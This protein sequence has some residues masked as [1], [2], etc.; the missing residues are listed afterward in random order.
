MIGCYRC[1]VNLLLQ[2]RKRRFYK[3]E[4]QNKMYKFAHWHIKEKGKRGSYA[5]KHTQ[6][7]IY[8]FIFVIM[9]HDRAHIILFLIKLYRNKTCVQ[10]FYKEIRYRC[11]RD[12]RVFIQRCITFCCLLF[13]LFF[14]FPLISC[15]LHLT[16]KKSYKN[17]RKK[18]I[19]VVDRN[20]T[21]WW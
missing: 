20:A 7:H 2:I 19:L 11:K 8:D 12:S 21:Y 5:H 10:H 9:M 6:L 4:V 13:Y 3:W 16:Q 17:N 18:V 1:N 14:Y 15:C